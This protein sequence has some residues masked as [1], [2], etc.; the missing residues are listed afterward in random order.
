M[1]LFVGEIWNFGKGTGLLYPSDR[2]WG[3]KGL[4]YGLGTS[5]PGGFEPKYYSNSQQILSLFRCTDTL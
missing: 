4:F 2:S 5:G 3:T 1:N